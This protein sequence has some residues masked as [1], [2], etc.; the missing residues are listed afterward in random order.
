MAKYTV[1]IK[2]L[3]DNNFD[4]QMN[5]YPIFDEN[6][7]Q[8][9]NHN[10]LYHYYENEIGQ[11][12][13]ALFRLF[14]NQK[15]N[16]IMP[17]YNVLY[18]IQKEMIEK[19]LFLNNVDITESLEGTNSQQTSSSSTSSNSGTSKNKN[20]FQDTPQGEITNAE[21]DNQNWATN[22]TLDSNST[23]NEIK[24]SS[25]SNGEGTN[26]YIKKIVGNNGNKF[27]IDILNDIK[28]NFNNIDLMIINELSDLFMG[29]F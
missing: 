27:N 9:L 3:M 12:T 15:L 17:K 11:E 25:S 8:T 20:L 24:D 6:Y 28:N 23:N 22:L 29:I 21:I 1:T 13:A 16:E 18:K 14:L 26:S 2:S 7:R 10:I 5:T 19:N 4:F